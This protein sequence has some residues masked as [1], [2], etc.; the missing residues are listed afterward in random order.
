M[1]IS[2]KG[3]LPTIYKGTYNSVRKINFRNEQKT[4]TD[5]KEDIQEANQHMQMLYI[6]TQDTTTHKQTKIKNTSTK[7]AEQVE[8]PYTANYHNTQKVFGKIC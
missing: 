7:Y 3:N 1:Y 5:T 8:F 6:K 2:N 4:R